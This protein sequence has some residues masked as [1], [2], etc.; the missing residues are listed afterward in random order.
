[1]LP[2]ASLSMFSTEPLEPMQTGSAIDIVA[3]R[4]FV[5]QDADLS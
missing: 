3:G 2:I 5:Q 1:M 4:A